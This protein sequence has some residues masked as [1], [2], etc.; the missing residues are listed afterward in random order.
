MDLSSQSAWRHAWNRIAADPHVVLAVAIVFAALVIE[1]VAGA[2]ADRA[3]RALGDL[4]HDPDGARLRGPAGR[5][6]V[7]DTARLLIALG[8]VFWMSL[9]SD[10]LAAMPL[11][12]L[13][14]LIVALAAVFGTRQAIVLGAAAMSAFLY[15]GVPRPRCSRV[16]VTPRRPASRCRP[17]RHDDRAGDRDPTDHRVTRTGRRR[18]PTP[19][20]PDSAGAPPRWPRSRRSVGR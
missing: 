12:C 6:A 3:G 16:G 5:S 14:L 17:G 15:A 10:D 11:S 1:L 2:N 8:V 13:Y 7:L 20:R 19:H 9:R 18:G 4:S